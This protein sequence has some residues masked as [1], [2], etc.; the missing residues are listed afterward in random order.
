MTANTRTEGLEELLVGHAEGSLSEGQAKEL[1]ARLQDLPEL[2]QAFDRYSHT[3][4]RLRSLPREKA[5]P[6][7]SRLIMRRVRRRR[8]FSSRSLHTTYAHFRVPAEALVPI[9]VAALVA[10]YFFYGL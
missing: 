6:A 7:L 9:L 8:F 10:L 4:A 3:V 1:E 2:R 5:P